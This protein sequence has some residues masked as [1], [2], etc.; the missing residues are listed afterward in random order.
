MNE[1]K[2]KELTDSIF[3]KLNDQ[4]RVYL[5]WIHNQKNKEIQ[6]LREENEFL[7]LNNPEMN[8]EHSRYVKENKRKIDN[9]RLVNK[10]LNNIINKKEQ[11]LG[12]N[13]KRLERE[14]VKRDNIINEFD[15]WL[16]NEIKFQEIVENVHFLRK[17]RI[18]LQELKG[19]NSNENL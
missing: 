18:K 1:K 11:F 19:S 5:A 17:A 6:E 14:V 13:I 15:K 2:A 10:R 7:K 16:E 9:L 4:E 12:D 8:I 3:N